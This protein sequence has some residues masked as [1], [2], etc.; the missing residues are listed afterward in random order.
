MYFTNKF[1]IV[2]CKPLLVRLLQLSCFLSTCSARIPTQDIYGLWEATKPEYR[3]ISPLWGF[4]A[5]DGGMLEALRFYGNYSF[6]TNAQEQR[7]DIAANDDPVARL[8]QKFFPSRDGE[9]LVPSSYIREPAGFLSRHLESINDIISIL[10]STDLIDKK[11]SIVDI[12]RPK[13]NGTFIHQKGIDHLTGEAAAQFSETLLSAHNYSSTNSIPYPQNTAIVALM[14]FFVSTADK[15]EDLEKL[16]FLMKDGFKTTKDLKKF[17][18]TDVLNH[19]PNI[20]DIMRNS[21]TNPELAFLMNIS[22]LPDI[23]TAVLPYRC[24]IKV[25]DK[26]QIPDCVETSLRNFFWKI[27]HLAPNTLENFFINIEKDNP[28]VL[29]HNPYKKLKGFVLDRLLL[30]LQSQEAHS[31]WA[32]IVSGLNGAKIELDFDDVAYVNKTFE[33]ATS[34]SAYHEIKQLGGIY[35][36][37]NV[38]AKLIPDP[39]FTESWMESHTIDVETANFADKVHKKTQTTM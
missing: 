20:T 3:H 16:T 37:F 14:A 23:Y 11:S 19:L 32:R 6:T 2:F 1:W 15:A 12:L 28:Q 9:N 30:G 13:R 4:V 18:E 26:Q 38:I 21:D 10:L 24:D 39:I 35:N 22:A 25:E 36:M 27:S 7:M 8:I 5:L 17:T 34:A 31:A 29:D 33:I